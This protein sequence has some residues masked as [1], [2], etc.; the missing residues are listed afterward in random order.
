MRSD[1]P[2]IGAASIAARRA[3]A[4]ASAFATRPGRKRHPGMRRRKGGVGDTLAVRAL[5]RGHEPIRVLALACIEPEHLLVQVCVEVE[6]THRDIR[7]VQRAL[8]ARPKVSMVF[9]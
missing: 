2:L 5:E 8:D 6:R 4:R 1:L 3:A 7:P 9:V